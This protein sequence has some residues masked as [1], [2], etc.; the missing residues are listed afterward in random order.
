MNVLCNQS[1]PCPAGGVGISNPGFWGM[2]SN[3]TIVFKEQYM[4]YF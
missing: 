2:V 3:L 4:N 1:N